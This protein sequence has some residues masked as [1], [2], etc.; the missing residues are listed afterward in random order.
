MAAIEFWFSIGSTYTY[1]TVARLAAVEAA[2]GI[3]FDWRPFNVRTIMVAQNNIPF[4][5][6]PA[7]A[8]YMWRDV[9]RRA[10]RHGRAPRLPAPYPI[11]DLALAN[12]V[13]LLG[14]G[15][16]WGRAYVTETYRRWFDA[17]ED[18]GDLPNITAS[19]RHAGQDP[20]ATLVRARSAETVAALVAATEWATAAGIFGSP[21]FRVGSE[22]FWGDDRLEDAIDWHRHGRLV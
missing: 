13:A 11:K 17:G 3:A 14:M 5:H 7:K 19:L 16:G 22:L 10:A 8:A 1:V 6:K 20:E 18:A 4:S 21:S 2:S 9:A 15:E 12:Q